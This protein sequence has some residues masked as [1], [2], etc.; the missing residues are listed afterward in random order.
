MSAKVAES[1]GVLE[2]KAN[3]KAK[4]KTKV[5]LLSHKILWLARTLIFISDSNETDVLARTTAKL[6]GP[7]S[8][9]KAGR[10]WT[11][12]QLGKGLYKILGVSELP[13]LVQTLRLAMIVIIDAHK[14]TIRELRSPCGD[15]GHKHGSGGLLI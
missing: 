11:C 10:W 6:V 8:Y 9:Y 4:V 12:G 3:S 7:A 15:L 5:T 14:K 13:I 1:A 2:K